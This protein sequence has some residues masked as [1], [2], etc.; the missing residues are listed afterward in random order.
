MVVENLFLGF[1]EII[2]VFYNDPS[3]VWLLFPIFLLWIASEIYYGEYQQEAGGF[4]SIFTGAISLLWVGFI[5][6]RFIFHDYLDILNAPIFW[7]VVAF[8]VYGFVIMYIA[9]R[10]ALDKRILKIIAPMR[11]IY[12]LSISIILWGVG[13][14]KLDFYV[15]IAL[16][17]IFIVLSLLFFILRRYFLGGLLGEVE[18]IKKVGK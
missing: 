11:L 10:H 9:F 15:M 8:M 5:S 18:A 17:L 4:S 3:I 2:R 6:M 14:L 1:S 16:F 12:F 13:R 7:V